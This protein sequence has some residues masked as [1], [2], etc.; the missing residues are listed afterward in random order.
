MSHIL[1]ATDLSEPAM[2]AALYAWEIFGP[3]NS[4]VM[5]HTYVQDPMLLGKYD[6]VEKAIRTGFEDYAERFIRTTGSDGVQ[7]Q[8]RIGQVASVL[9]EVVAKRAADVVV[10]GNRGKAGSTLFFGSNTVQVIQS[11]TVPVLAIPELAEIKRPKRILL[12]TDHGDLE[13][14]TLDMVHQ[15]ALSCDAEVLIG[16]VQAME[17]QDPPVLDKHMFEQ[18]LNGVPHSYQQVRADDLLE[19]MDRIARREGA[20]MIAVVHRHAGFLGRLLHPS[21]SKAIAERIN[22][23]LLVLQQIAH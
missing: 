23:P 11:S 14:R 7:R 13:A 2:H 8:V 4:Y 3:T 12:A 18:A 1:I 9:E 17:S 21:A 20:D 16:H 5:L 19:G 15:I 10:M 22:L 6:E